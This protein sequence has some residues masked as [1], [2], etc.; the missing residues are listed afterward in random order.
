VPALAPLLV[1][2]F[3]AVGCN[4]LDEPIDAEGGFRMVPTDE[5]PAL[6]AATAPPPLNGG[7]LLVTADGSLAIVTDEARDRLGVVDLRNREL[8]GNVQFSPGSEPGRAALGDDGAVYVVLRRKGSVARV[9]LDTLELSAEYPVCA[10]PRGI[11]FDAAT[12]SL[13]VACASGSFVSLSPAGERQR[14]VQLPNDLRDVVVENGNVWVSRFRSAEVLRLG[15]DG[16]I[17][18]RLVPPANEHRRLD[19]DFVE[20]LAVFEPNVGYRLTAN[21]AGGVVL[22]HQ[23]STTESISLEPDGA[24]GTAYGNGAGCNGIQRSVVTTFQPGGIVVSSADVGVSLPLDVAMLA[25]G[26][27]LVLGAGQ[28][29]QGAPV[30]SFVA[31]GSGSF[32]AALPVAFGMASPVISV[33]IEGGPATIDSFGPG[34]VV[35]PPDDALT[36]G[37][38]PPPSDAQQY[39]VA[40]AAADVSN[41]YLVQTRDPAQL[42]IVDRQNVVRVPLGGGAIGDTGF[43]LFHRNAEAGLSCASCH[44]SGTEDDH[45]WS[46]EGHGPRRTQPL[47]VQLGG[48]APFH[49]D[50][51]LPDVPELMSQVYVDRMGGVHQSPERRE[52]LER[53][54]FSLAPVVAEAP[55]ASDRVERGRRLFE[56]FTVGCVDCHRGPAMTDNNSY[57]VGTGAPGERFQVPSL[58]GLGARSRFMHDGCARTLAERFEPA[59]GGDRHGKL[60]ELAPADLADLVVFLETL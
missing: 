2:S 26:R 45:V 18:E 28:A 54:M 55:I 17:A 31:G 24:G 50:G 1:L 60:A 21:P 30:S 34:C 41:R 44:A 23:A 42:L 59:C 7:T 39:Y 8:Q 35:Q 16:S 48:T 53:W 32:G 47:D 49:W 29:D 10:A 36:R 40:V 14:S 22:V 37:D 19:A 6:Q 46:F 58:L 20:R 12:R 3:G 27:A 5:R 51:S 9:S 43:D 15:A 13:Y 57:D 38:S 33:D 56:S 25:N 4:A 11:A 52:A